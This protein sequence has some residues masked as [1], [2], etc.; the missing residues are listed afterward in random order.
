MAKQPT[1]GPVLIDLPFPVAGLDVALPLE[2]QRKFTTPECQNVRAFDPKSGRNRGSRRSGLKKFLSEQFAVSVPSVDVSVS[3]SLAVG[4]QDLIG[5]NLARDLTVAVGD[6]LCIANSS[7]T[8][9]E[10]LSSAGASLKVTSMAATPLDGCFDLDGYGYTIGVTGSTLKVV[11]IEPASLGSD[12]VWTASIA[13]P[14][15]GYHSGGCAVKD[16][17]LYA[18][19]GVW[20]GTAA[21][22]SRI[23]R[24]NVADG[25]LVAADGTDGWKK[26]SSATTG[27]VTP[28]DP[29]DPQS[30]GNR[31]GFMAISGNRL[32]VL[33]KANYDTT[34]RL[35]QFDLVTGVLVQRSLNTISGGDQPE[36]YALCADTVGN[37]YVSHRGAVSDKV[38]KIDEAGASLWSISATDAT[39]PTGLA[40]DQ[41]NGRIGAVNPS[42]TLLDVATSFCLINPT[43]GARSSAS[44]PSG[45]TTWCVIAADGLGG[46]RIGNRAGAASVVKKLDSSLA[47]AWTS[48]ARAGDCSWIASTSDYIIEHV[49]MQSTRALRMLAV[50]E[51]AL[52]RFD[53]SDAT[54]IASAFVRQTSPVVFS[55]QNGAYVYYVD[56]TRYKRYDAYNN[57]TEDWTASSGSLPSDVNLETARLIE[58]W[59][60]RTVLAGL[61]S[62]PQNWFMSAVNDPR[63]WNYS[64]TSTSESQAVA[65]NNS[66]AGKVG[67]AITSLVPYSDDVLLIGGDHSIYAITGDPMAGGRIDLISESIG[68]AWGRP[69]CKDP[70]GVLWFFSSRCGIYRMVPGQ[71]LE[72]VS[73]PID[74]KLAAINLATNIVRMAWDDRQQGLHV[75]IAPLAAP[76]ATTH[77][78]F[79]ARNKA[80]FPDVFADTDHDPKA[81]YVFDADDPN[82]RVLV[83]GSWD[84]YLRTFGADAQDDDGTPIDSYVL[85]GPL[86]ASLDGTF[87]LRSFEAILAKDSADL[88][89]GAMIA[90]TCEQALVAAQKP[91]GT[92]TKGRNTWRA[93]R[94]SG[95]AGYLRL[96]YKK[97][98]AGW[99]FERL[100][101]DLYL[102]GQQRRRAA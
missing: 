67:D 43:T 87:M 26:S 17:I 48:A 74:E 32:G 59:H 34:V 46:F 55:A 81:V 57:V 14:A 76:G 52:F 69:Y 20:S 31:G 60:G 61:R 1:T 15:A 98:A 66:P 40:Y 72:R 54:E 75:F 97:K 56:G 92:L 2:R 73:Q 36:A 25:S 91:K 13:L 33:G 8:E 11:K 71:L 28:S 62:D 29:A 99:T 77:Y 100:T 50:F 93:V 86:Q 63:D 65:G 24:I 64:P 7:T 49:S 42:G 4:F 80:W 70:A 84:G 19:C 82:D 35:Q 37:F 38:E 6:T 96:G 102:Y 5:I 22:R 47:V 94:R 95:R 21:D 27:L 79:D 89:W 44:N 58:T 41:V 12:I 30:G 45:V 51:G 3:G 16:D 9:A 10:R 85:L 68:M 90:N 18:F 53:G 39:L 78:W 88:D 83:L 101:A 23:F